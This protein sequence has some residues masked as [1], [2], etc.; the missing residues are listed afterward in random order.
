MKGRSR[1]RVRYGIEKAHNVDR[2]D[3]FGRKRKHPNNRQPRE[4]TSSGR[5]SDDDVALG[6]MMRFSQSSVP[7]LDCRADGEM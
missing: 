5:R 4:V 2:Q 3:R 6:A 1:R 7:V